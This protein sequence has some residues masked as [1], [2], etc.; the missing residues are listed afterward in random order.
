MDDSINY[1]NGKI[2][3]HVWP[4]NIYWS[5]KDELQFGE[6]EHVVPF[7]MLQCLQFAHEQILSDIAFFT[8]SQNDVCSRKHMFL[9]EIQWD[10]ELLLDDIR[11]K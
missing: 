10:L 4:N 1:T 6:I 11:K 3:F 5:Y 8:C 7:S 2:T 9:E